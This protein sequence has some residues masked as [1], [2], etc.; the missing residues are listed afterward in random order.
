VGPPRHARCYAALL[1]ATTRPSSSAAAPAPAPDP[2]PA[3]ARAARAP[4]RASAPAADAAR[5]GAPGWMS[6]QTWT[7]RT[8]TWWGLA[9][10][11]RGGRDASLSSR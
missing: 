11:A 4:R 7:T 1:P 5:A 6:S 3:A 8:V 9:Q 2:A 10:A